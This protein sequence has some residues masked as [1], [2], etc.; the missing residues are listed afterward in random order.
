MHHIF[1]GRFLETQTFVEISSTDHLILSLVVVSLLSSCSLIVGLDPNLLRDLG[2][3]IG[4]EAKNLNTAE[5]WRPETFLIDPICQLIRR[6]RPQPLHQASLSPRQYKCKS[7][8]LGRVDY[9]SQSPACEK[10]V[11]GQRFVT[12]G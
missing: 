4:S 6:S 1:H 8:N 10:T 11:K 3:V 7:Y 5:F 2:N 9:D 12:F